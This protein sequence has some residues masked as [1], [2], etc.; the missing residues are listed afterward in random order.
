MTP[1]ERT[2]ALQRIAEIDAHL[3][4]TRSSVDA[5]NIRESIVLY[6]ERAVLLALVEER[7]AS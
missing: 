6:K 1:E 3:E 4:A 2:Q 7:E 5:E